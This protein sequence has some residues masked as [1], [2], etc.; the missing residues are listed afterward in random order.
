MD[1]AD[2]MRGVG[3]GGGMVTDDL[4]GM[5]D[6]R[7]YV[8]MYAHALCVVSYRRSHSSSALASPSS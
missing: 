1:T 3:W 2:A 4:S 7:I 5:M 6:G 8:S